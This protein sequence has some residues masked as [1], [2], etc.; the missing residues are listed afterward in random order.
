MPWRVVLGNH[1]HQG[2]IQAQ[3]NL[4]KTDPYWHMKGNYYF[5]TF[6][7]VFIAFLDTTPLYYSEK[8]MDQF[9]GFDE[10]MLDGQIQALNSALR[11]SR[12]RIK[13]V[14]G[15]HPIISFGKNSIN[16]SINMNQLKTI[17]FHLLR[18]NKVSAYFSGHE[19]TM[20]HHIL[21]GLNMF[22]SG[23]GSK[24]SPIERV[25]NH[26]VFALDRQGFM[27]VSVRNNSD[28]LDISF[29]DFHG[30]VVHSAHIEAGPRFP[31]VEDRGRP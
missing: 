23:A 14:V 25:T 22:V 26:T 10:M 9:G 18:D 21:D 28:A 13:I 3:M 20:E 16:E 24:L 2:S 19:H 8:E 31:S 15:H 5:E 4:A 1:D 30:A 7:E 29:I 17:L 11:G 12:Q 27:E 6:G